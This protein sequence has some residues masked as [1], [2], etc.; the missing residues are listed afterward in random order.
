MEKTKLTIILRGMST[1][2]G[3]K[4][5][6]TRERERESAVEWRAQPFEK[7]LAAKERD[8]EPFT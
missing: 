7:R 6:G 1:V 2:L 4:E 8:C 3:R 5:E